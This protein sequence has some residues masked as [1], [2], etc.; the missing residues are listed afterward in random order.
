NRLNE[1]SK[2][3]KNH[4][5]IFSFFPQDMMKQLI[6]KLE[7]CWLDLSDEMMKLARNNL[8]ALKSKIFVTKVL[9]ALDEYTKPNCK[10]RDLFMKYQEILC[11][12]VIDTSKVLKAIEEHL[13]T[14]V[15][16][17]MS[18][19]NQRR[20]GDGQVEKAFEEVKGSLA[21]SLK[22]LTKNTMMKVFL[23]GESEVDLKNVIKL[24]E[25]LQWIEDAKNFVFEY[26]DKK[27]QQDIEKMEYETKA[28]IEKWILKIVEKI[29][30]AI[31]SCNF[32]EAEEKIQLVQKFTRILGSR[33]EQI[34][35]D[36][37]KEENIKEGTSKI[38]NNVDSLEKQVEVVLKGV[39]NK[40]KKIKLSDCQFNPYVSNSPKDLYAKLNKV[41]ESVTTSNYKE[42]WTEIEEDII[43]KVRDL[44]LD[45]RGKVSNSNSRESE[46]CIRLC[47]SVLN[48]LP[49]RVQ[50]ILK[51][52]IQQCR[53]DIK[54]EIEN[55][56]KEV[57]QVIQN[58]DIQDIS[59]LLDRYN[60]GRAR[61]TINSGVNKMAREIVA[62]ISEQMANGEM[63]EMH[64]SLI[65]LCHFKTLKQ[66]IVGLDQHFARVRENLTS[67]FNKYHANIVTNFARSASAIAQM[68]KAFDF[69]FVC[70]EFKTNS[71]DSID[72]DELLPHN[73]N[74]NIKK[75]NNTISE[76]FDSHRQRYKKNIEAMNTEEIQ[77]VLRVMKTVSEECKFLHNFS[78][79]L[80]QGCDIS[81][82]PAVQIWTYPEAMSELNTHLEK[83]IEEMVSSGIINDKTKANDM[84]RD[85]YFN[86]L[87]NK[88][89]FL[90]RLSLNEHINSKIFDN[91]SKKLESQMQLLVK[92]IKV[93]SKSNS[94]NCEQVNLYYNCFISMQ[95]NGVL[96]N[97]VQV[98]I[99]VIEDIVND[100][101]EKLEEEA[102]SNLSIEKI[103]PLLL[104]MKQMSIHIF[105]FKSVVDKRIDEILGAY[106]RQ[107][108][109][110]MSISQ[111]ALQLE[112]NSNRIG[113]II[114]AEHNLFKGY[115]VS[116]FNMNTKSHG[117]EYV[118]QKIETT[119]E[120]KIFEKLRKRYDEFDSIYRKLIKDNL[121][122]D[123]I[124]FATIVN[125]TKL[126]THS[127]EQKPDD[128]IWDAKIRNN[129]PSLIAHI[130]ALWTLQNAQFYFDAKGVENQ[131]S[132]LLQPHAAQVISIFRMLGVDENK[133]GLINNLVQ[134][135]TGEG[136]SVTLAVVSCV[137]AFDYL[138][139]RDFKSFEPLFSALGI[140]D[141]IHYGTFK[142]LCERI[143]NDGGD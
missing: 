40:Y 99:E 8:Q 107:H 106:K 44:L 54:Y 10:F 38:V 75:L 11:N 91:C 49:E 118:L 132:Y 72:P 100:R 130:F 95:K 46:A 60:S 51:D 53:E 137:L 45:A 14:E 98:Q 59:E 32:R 71:T 120:E 79:M 12:D 22:A 70:L 129:V 23:L 133:P 136:K 138:S 78:F 62:C 26:V 108:K 134:I 4:P 63:A 31:N 13:Y 64:K 1:I 117:I 87:K 2:L 74:E 39:V 131:S 83:M 80:K 103:I 52:E 28:S 19:L 41:M 89:D 142:K 61:I 111:L 88:L 126:N 135:G 73:F 82:D 128:V 114:V 57:E 48:S 84:E 97:A 65:K 20:D 124:N 16:A 30:V 24:E 102:M 37:N 76:F 81:G 77:S 122:E 143:I 67:A 94:I 5:V 55:A 101:I 42:A 109:S 66:K 141:H 68:K 33:F 6:G 113:K 18:K 35:F 140:T 139:G 85:Q 92:Q 115:F 34:S 29:K 58:K 110:G 121:Q 43:K 90:R 125:N 17:E 96:S 3:E 86:H 47:E 36:N 25:Q 27:T 69:I 50:G 9:S 123:K 119:Q 56:L 105:S 112:K 104:A 15:A 21:R 116:L 127:I 93:V 7:K